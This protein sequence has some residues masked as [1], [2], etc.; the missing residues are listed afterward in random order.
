MN[1][2]IHQMIAK[3]IYP[4]EVEIEGEADKADSSTRLF[5]EQEVCELGDAGDVNEGVFL[6][7]HVIKHERAM[8]EEQLRGG[9]SRRESLKL[10]LLFEQT[11]LFLAPQ[12]YTHQ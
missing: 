4:P 1:D 6:N 7:N 9:F 3:G 5:R 2:D 8:K 10:Y 12:H 11:A